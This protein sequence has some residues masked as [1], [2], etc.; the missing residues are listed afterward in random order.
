MVVK[1]GQ[2]LVFGRVRMLSAKDE[3][4]EYSAFRFDPWD[5]PFFGTGPRMALELRQLF[6]PGGAF[7]YKAHPAPPVEADGSFFWI[8]SAG[9]YELLGNPRLLGSKQ[10]TEGETFTL[11]RFS[12]P[13]TGGTLYVGTLIISVDFDVVDF[14]GAWKSDEAEYEIRSLRVVDEGE[15]ELPKLRERFPSLPEPVATE[16]MRT[17]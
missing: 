2:A 16:C 11:A 4:I 7:R 6:P 9:D 3:N 14:I 5:Q 10:F 17:E 1:P 13:A 12:V 8:L 15:G